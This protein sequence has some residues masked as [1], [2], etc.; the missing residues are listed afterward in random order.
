[1]TTSQQT[2]S[3][4]DQSKEPERNEHKEGVSTVQDDARSRSPEPAMAR[5]ENKND[6]SETISQPKF[7]R[8]PA[9]Y[10]A[11]PTSKP[12][13]QIV[14]PPPGQHPHPMRTDQMVYECYDQERG[15]PCIVPPRSVTPLQ[16]RGKTY[17]PTERSRDMSVEPG[18]IER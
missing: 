2:I 9:T 4:L 15:I 11:W 12:G 7:A 17:V 6:P 5:D 10:P 1:M 16:Q 14:L 3:Q 18:E 13:P 8:H